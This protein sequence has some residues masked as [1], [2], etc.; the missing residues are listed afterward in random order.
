MSGCLLRGFLALW[1]VLL[2]AGGVVLTVRHLCWL[3]KTW[4]SGPVI[5]GLLLFTLSILGIFMQLGADLAEGTP[6]S[7][8]FCQFAIYL[9][10]VAIF[11]P[12]FVGGIWLLLMGVDGLLAPRLPDNVVRSVLMVAGI[13]YI[14]AVLE[15]LERLIERG[16]IALRHRS[17]KQ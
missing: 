6:S 16:P 4:F 15:V 14:A 3:D 7:R 13:G 9:A 8:V 1:L 17:E 5:F 12:T 10:Q 2:L 11:I